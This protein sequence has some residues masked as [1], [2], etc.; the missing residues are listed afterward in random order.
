MIVTVMFSLT[1]KKN[2]GSLSIIAKQVQL[3]GLPSTNRQLTRTMPCSVTEY[4]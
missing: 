3:Q 4:P 2:E 1:Y